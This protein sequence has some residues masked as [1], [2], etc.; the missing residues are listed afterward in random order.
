ME[1]S[2]YRYICAA[3][4]SFDSVALVKYQDEKYAADLMCMNPELD[5]V[6]TFTGGEVLILPVVEVP[7]N[8][9]ENGADSALPTTAP[10]KE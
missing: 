5:R 3:G 9:L 4:E 10:W 1:D 7:E 2:G 8:A 6:Q